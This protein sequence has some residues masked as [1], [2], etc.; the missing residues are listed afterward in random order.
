MY[1]QNSYSNSYGPFLPRPSRTFTDGAFGPF[2]PIQPVPVDEPPPGGQFADPRLWQ[3]RVGWNL[4]TPPGTEGLK[5]ASFEQL[6]TLSNRYSVARACIELRKEEIRGL[7]WEINLTTDAAK[8]YQGDHKAMKD[9]GERKAEATKFFKH[10]DPDFWNFSSFLDAL[11]EEILVYDA[12]ALIF[13]PKYG[14]SFGMGG[15]GLLGSDLDSLNLISGPTIRPLV[16]MHGEKPR[17]PAPAYQQ[18]LY[19]VPRSDYMTLATG[20]DIDDYGLQGAEVNDFRS[21]IMLYAPLVSRRETP[22]GFPP[23]ERALL[24]II[25]GLQKQEFQL[26][27]YTEGTVPAV[28]ISPG[29]PNITPTQI[30]E[31]QNALNALAGD[32]AYHLKVVVLP[33]GS[34][35]EPQR[36]V[37]LSDS[38]DNLVMTQV[39]MAFDVQTTELS[40]LPNVGGTS[41]GG[42]ANASALRLAAQSSRDIKSRKSTKP[43]LQWI[44]DIFNH[45]LQDICN[46][47]DMQFQFEGLVDDED[48]QA[49]TE[50]G[51]QQVQN[52]ISSID[53]IRERLDLPPWGLQETSEPVV[54]TA[55]GP[56]PLSMAPQLIAAMQQGGSNGQGTNSGQRTS[57]SRSRTKQPTVRAGGQTKPNG[58]HPAP[59]SPH[60]EGVTPG[61]SAASGAIQSPTPRT[62]GTTSRS[63]VAGSRKKA[64]TAELD[65]LKRHLRKGRQITTWDPVHITNRILGMIAEDI[66]KGVLL[67]V[68]IDRAGDL[69]IA[70]DWLD[71][72]EDAQPD[73][74]SDP[75]RGKTVTQFPGW[76]HD[77]GLVGAYKQQ[78]A[79]AFAAA[80]AKGSQIRKDAATGKMWVDNIT[81]RGLVSDAAK[82]VF[83]ATLTPLWTEAWH[84][85]YA[86][87]KSLVTG[88]PAD[89][90]SKE[91]SEHLR[92]FLNTEGEHWLQQIMR[93]GLANSGSR[94][95]MI[96]RTEV[97]RA[98]NTAALQCYKDHGVSYKHLLIAPDDTCD[99]CLDAAEDEDIPLDAPFSKGGTLG[100]VHVQCR[101]VPAPAGIEAIP[102]QSHIGKSDQEDQSR[103]AWLLFRAKDEKDH[104]RYLLQ[105]RDDGSWGMPGGTTHVGEN[106]W[107]AAVREV[108][109]EIGDL[110]SFRVVHDFSHTDP[111]GVKAYLW[112][113]ETGK[114][115]TPKMNGSTP[116][117]TLSTAWFRRGE[118]GSLDLTKKFRD[119]WEKEVHL[120]ENLR[121]L[122]SLQRMVNENGE[123]MVLDTPGQ[124]LQ[125]VGSRWPYPHRADGTEDPE[126]HWRDAG[127]G[128]YPGASPGGDPP[129]DDNFADTTN[130]R[131][132]PRGDND[133][134]YPH[135]R[136]AA[137]HA[138]R[139]PDQGEE[140]EDFWPEL[141]VS[142][143]PSGSGVP[144]GKLPKNDSGHPVV[145]VVP[146]KTPK[147]YS[148]RAVP[149]EVYD[150]GEAVEHWDPAADSDVVVPVGKGSGGP[151]DYRD[152]NETDPE[153]ILSQLRSNFPEDKIAWVKRARWIG[154][155]EIPW[156]RIDDHDIEE[157]AASHQADAVNRFARDIKANRGHTNPSIL[158]QVPGREK[159]VVVDGH[160]RAL[161]RRKLG[162]PVLA[163]VGFIQSGD[164]QA[165]E[166]T[167][168]SQ[169]HSGSDSQNK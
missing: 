144:S 126:L 79:D 17:P 6:W 124:R 9:F 138:S 125:A 8:A 72:S 30:G 21:D 85:G 166:E 89:F 92:G 29:D 62:G 19:G 100:L 40:I 56:I 73:P 110:P 169:F 86:S 76:Q 39:C 122:K 165:A 14:A 7:E 27:Y 5:L 161:A 103:V 42:G 41:A 150:P 66:A 84:L 141:E 134:A 33:P 55:Q 143:Q 104:W 75:H 136:Q 96:A 37:D 71:A 142:G 160:H 58:S 135:A 32:P 114:I 111:D 109:E 2:S 47:P 53:E 153:H 35:V 132:Y 4:P 130:P 115:F 44:C 31:L 102:P 140:D 77:L 23:V 61:H 162:K 25:S 151:G 12:L 50:L 149:P 147:P 95:E 16:G 91:D 26:D 81:L 121:L 38:F 87:A 107:D 105:Q 164:I 128:A 68:A 36:P 98:M 118:I 133:E 48:K 117:E 24:P 157:W 127:P 80:E 69:D 60:R 145:G 18:Y 3:Y 51:V 57:S 11:L 152:P 28:Y 146:P 63:S 20:Q 45:V 137:P 46:Q 116:E 67:D 34:R 113:C 90:T 154:P 97:A 74:G 10:P 106:G 83:T 54:F 159:A 1:L 64:V 129:H 52:A 78:V 163:Y 123:Q 158:V 120:E 22:Y 167:H 15:R 131:V 112:L 155:V 59:V 13:R 139:F 108:T 49:I 43:L 119:D 82:S 70:K 93:T 156:E 88:Q 148:P 99:D 101:C 65:A 168:S 94:S